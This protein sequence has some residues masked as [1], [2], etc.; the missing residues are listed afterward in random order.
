MCNQIQV[1][2]PYAAPVLPLRLFSGLIQLCEEFAALLSI[3]IRQTDTSAA[4]R[5]SEKVLIPI[6]LP[7]L[8][9][10]TNS[11]QRIAPEVFDAYKDLFVPICTFPARLHQHVATNEKL[12]ELSRY[13]LGSSS[14]NRSSGT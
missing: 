4:Q 10:I 5:Y 8:D 2:R 14:C 1:K 12:P 11:Y 9:S 13:F 7:I 6:V 3:N